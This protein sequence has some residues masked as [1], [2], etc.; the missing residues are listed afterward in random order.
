MMPPPNA[1]LPANLTADQK[2]QIQL[3]QRYNYQKHL[4]A[5]HYAP[6]VDDFQDGKHFQ[7]CDFPYIC[8]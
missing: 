5:L 2:H 3:Q 1:P 4:Q 8:I 7:K 6:Q